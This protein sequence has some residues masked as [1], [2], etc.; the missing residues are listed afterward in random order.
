MTFAPLNK[1]QQRRVA[2]ALAGEAVATVKLSSRRQ[3]VRLSMVEGGLMQGL[4]ETR[5]ALTQRLPCKEDQLT[6]L[7]VT[8]ARK[9]APDLL[10]EQGAL[11]SAANVARAAA[12]AQ[13]LV[14]RFRV[15]GPETKVLDRAYEYAKK[16]VEENRA[17]IEQV[18]LELII[19][20]E[21]SAEQVSAIVSNTKS[22]PGQEC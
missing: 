20:S 16:F 15:K 22:S 1:E 18:A 11:P 5:P 3:L 4:C 17:V 7:H 10:C 2:C 9:A 14:A 6:D 21:L 8:M 19:Q 13:A 12:M